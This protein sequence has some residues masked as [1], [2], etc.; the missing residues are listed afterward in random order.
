MNET[1]QSFPLVRIDPGKIRRQ[2]FTQQS[3]LDILDDPFKRD[4]LLL[5]STHYSAVFNSVVRDC[6]K[7]RNI[8]KVCYLID[9]DVLRDYLEARSIDDLGSF[10]TDVLF[11][12][13]KQEYGIPIGAFLELVDH[14]NELAETTYKTRAYSQM[15]PQKVIYQIA[16]VVGVEVT[17]EM[18]QDE[19]IEAISNHIRGK[20]LALD[21]LAMFLTDERFVGIVSGYERDVVD[22][23][24]MSLKRLPRRRKGLG[25]RTKVDNRDAM[26]LAIALS[27]VPGT[28]RVTQDSLPKVSRG[29]ILISRTSII[30]RLLERLSQDLEPR[31][32]AKLIRGICDTLGIRETELGLRFPVMS[33]LEI[34][35]LEI[36]GIYE[37]PGQVFIQSRGLQDD[38]A[39]IVNYLENKMA[40]PVSKTVDELTNKLLANYLDAERKMVAQ[41]LSGITDVILSPDSEGLRRLEMFRATSESVGYARREQKDSIM[42]FDRL[43]QE[44]TALLSRLRGAKMVLAEAIE[45]AQLKYSFRLLNVDAG[46]IHQ[47]IEILGHWSDKHSTRIIEGE[48]YLA[49][50]HK[51][52]TKTEYYCLRWPVV[53]TEVEFLEAI[54]EMMATNTG[55]HPKQNGPPDNFMLKEITSLASSLWDEGIVI[56]TSNRVYGE[57]IT[58]LLRNEHWEF[59]HLDQLALQISKNTHENTVVGGTGHPYV[60]NI[61]QYRINTLFGDFA[62]DIE[63]VEGEISRYLTVISHFNLGSH[64]AILYKTTGMTPAI[65]ANLGSELTKALS[66]FQL[67]PK[68]RTDEE[69]R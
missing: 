33:P 62:F 67:L 27:T 29:Y 12:S 45:T 41:T 57:V 52:R 64:L 65:P 21:R 18:D 23:V 40:S 36:L 60:P 15:S 51:G 8:S 55:W 66:G 17:I 39:K 34:V 32:G 22:T 37:S 44:S 25:G 46:R 58:H 7:L 19:I 59:I 10:P 1:S 38:F 68:R 43:R 13:S 14:L 31:E 4:W 30:V 35:T 48:S 5:I 50:N 56:Y 9:F 28:K 26:N 20:S 61:Q 63:P 3:W 42:P 49:S 53:C 6:I 16:R 11:Y 2:E 24:K 69:H 54:K 47:R